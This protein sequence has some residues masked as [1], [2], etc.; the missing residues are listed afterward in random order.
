MHM[1]ERLAGAVVLGAALLFASSAAAGVEERESR[2]RERIA[3]GVEDGSLTRAEAHRLRHQQAN[4]ERRER[5][6][7]NNDGH[8]GPAERLRLHRQQDRAARNIFRRRHNE[9][10]R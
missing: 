7:R 1:C 5:R 2:Q 9:H 3:A 8:L 6:F 10:T 4:I